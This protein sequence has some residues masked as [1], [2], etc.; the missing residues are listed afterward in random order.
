MGLKLRREDNNF[1]Y[2]KN[3]ELL[4]INYQLL[5]IAININKV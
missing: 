4:I 1:L 3:R 5:N 2:Q